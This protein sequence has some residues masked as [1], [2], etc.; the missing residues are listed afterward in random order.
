MNCVHLT[1]AADSTT[2]VSDSKFFKFLMTFSIVI[3][4]LW[5]FL[6][7]KCLQTLKFGI[8]LLVKNL[9]EKEKYKFSFK[10]TPPMFKAK[11]DLR[12]DDMLMNYTTEETMLINKAASKPWHGAREKDARFYEFIIEGTTDKG[13][14]VLDCTASI[15]NF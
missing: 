2:M 3:H 11:V 8:T 14:L 13:A 6:T 9:G 12:R 15:R 5:L 1:S 4:F 7:L 10:R